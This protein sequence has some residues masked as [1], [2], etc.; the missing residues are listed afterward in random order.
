MIGVIGV[1]G[2]IGVI[3]VIGVIAYQRCRPTLVTRTTHSD[4]L[5][6]SVLCVLCVLCVYVFMGLWVYG[7]MSMTHHAQ[8]QSAHTFGLLKP[9]MEGHEVA[10]VATD[11]AVAAVVVSA[12]ERLLHTHGRLF[13]HW[14][15]T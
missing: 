10:A 15:F 6:G 11:A 7:F 3:G 1:I 12:E 2:M 14:R 8:P 4:R 5:W 13:N 9:P